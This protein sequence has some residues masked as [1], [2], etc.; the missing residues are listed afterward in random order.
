MC[1]NWSQLLPVFGEGLRG[2]ALLE[3]VCHQRRALRV[4]RAVLFP[5]HPLRLVFEDQG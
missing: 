5:V 3:E 1:L 2:V 4:Y